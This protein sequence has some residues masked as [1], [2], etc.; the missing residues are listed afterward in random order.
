VIC[1]LA[2]LRVFLYSAAFP[3][4]SNIDEQAHFDLVRKYSK[5]HIPRS[6]ENMSIET[7][8]YI[9]RYESPEYFNTP[10][11][12]PSKT[13]QSPPW[14]KSD[15]SMQRYY[16]E[17][18]VY[19]CNNYSN[20]ESSQAPL[21]Y[22]IAGGWVNLGKML[23]IGGGYLLYWIRFLNILFMVALVVIARKTAVELFMEDSFFRIGIPLLVAFIPQDSYYS[24]QNDVLSPVAFGL[25]FLLLIKY[26]N[27]EFKSNILALSAGLSLSLTMLVKI[28]NLPLF[29]ICI[30]SS[31]LLFI[32][33][34]R[35]NR[36]HY[37]TLMLFISSALIPVT[38]WFLRNYF[39]FGDLT[40][41]EEKIKILGWTHRNI[42]EWFQHPIFTFTGIKEFTI[43]IISTF[44]RGEMIWWTK[45]I[46]NSISDSFFILSTL[47]FIIAGIF[48]NKNNNKLLSQSNK[49]AIA[50]FISLILFM[51]LLSISFDFGNCENPSRMHPYFVSGR[52][53]SGALIPFGMLY[54][55][56]MNIAISKIENQKIK[57]YILTSVVAIITTLEYINHIPVFESKYNFFNL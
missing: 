40:G 34:Q 56:G 28:S 36:T 49:I 26:I 6:I 33:T 47:V 42:S 8:Y 2:A 11:N 25:T 13:F 16:S 50:S 4:F 7:A 53:I 38:I 15:L 37:I 31:L 19:W 9:P 1:L 45:P 32:R 54:L 12:Q 39:V 3:F 5:G 22:L 21:Y 35:I 46:A 48:I 51:I 18:M 41:S 29:P 52:L 24:I 27:S 30:T 17:G 44:W 57:L 10:E 14:T 23:G 20:H 55:Q 43:G